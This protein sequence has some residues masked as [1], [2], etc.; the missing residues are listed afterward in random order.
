VTNANNRAA[1]EETQ[2]MS[3]APGV[4]TANGDGSGVPAAL[5]LRVKAD[6]SQRFDL[7]FR[8]DPAQNRFVPAA[9][10][11]GVETDQ[12]FLVL[13]A[14][15]LRAVAPSAI[16]AGIGGKLAEVLFAGAAPGLDGI[17]Q[18]NIRLSRE[19]IG[20]GEVGVVLHADDQ[21]ANAVT[22]SVK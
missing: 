4:F 21:N 18:G 16:E 14:T 5:A 7:V 1:T 22:I 20:R 2:V 9:I 6:G 15:G 8:F 12:V 10:D 13:F 19:L 11:M 17:D 3:I